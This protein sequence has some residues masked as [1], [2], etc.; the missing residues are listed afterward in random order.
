MPEAYPENKDGFIVIAIDGGA[1]SGKSTTARA[2]AAR[3][4][5]L[6]VDTG[7]HYRAVTAAL[8]QNGVDV[9]DSEAV[10]ARLQQLRL[11]SRIVGRQSIIELDGTTYASEQLRSPEVNAVVS[12]AAAQP[13]VRGFLKQYQRTQLDVAREK[14]FAGLVMEGRDIGSVILPEAPYRF[15]LEAD[16]ATRQVRR[17]KEGQTDAIAQ[18]DR[19]DASRKSAPLTCPEGAVRLDTGVL[20][21]DEVVAKITSMLTE[22]AT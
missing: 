10:D 19:A 8:L 11:S 18:R 4:N 2:L 17:E 21:P 14:N 9:R 7:S 5:L 22:T 6:H 15:F 1:A 16:V 3:L 12:A 13:C 20:A